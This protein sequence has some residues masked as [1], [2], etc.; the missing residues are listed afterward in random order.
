MG[1]IQLLNDIREG[2]SKDFYDRKSDMFFSIADFNY[3]RES[4]FSSL[5]KN[6]CIKISDSKN[7]KKNIIALLRLKYNIWLGI[8]ELSI[9]IFKDFPK[10]FLVIKTINTLNHKHT[11]ISFLKG[12]IMYFAN[13]GYTGNNNWLKG[14]PLWN[15]LNVIEGTSIIPYVQIN[16]EYIEPFINE[17]SI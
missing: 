7:D 2:W 12:S 9:T 6:D 4:Y 3:Y 13:S 5:T 16:Y 14:I 15:D 10:S 8:D 1:Y 11:P 17:I